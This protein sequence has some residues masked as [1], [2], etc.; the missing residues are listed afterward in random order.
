MT[1]FDEHNG[2]ISS[3]AINNPSQFDFLNNMVL[4]SSYDWT[5]KLWNP[6][7][8]D[9]LRTFEFSDDYIYDI[10]WHPTNPSLFSTV[11]TD[12]YI[13]IFDLTRDLELPIAHE[14]VG[15]NA[16]NKSCWNND[17]SAIVTGDSTGALDLYVL[18]EKYRKMNSSKY[19]DLV[20]HLSQR[21]EAE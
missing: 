21:Q 19:E 8:K 20:R 4:T 9:S 1:L 5:V 3:L 16:L 14:K 13:D 2:P 7:F 17:G 18:S 11:N 6:Q 15:R 12:G 10:A